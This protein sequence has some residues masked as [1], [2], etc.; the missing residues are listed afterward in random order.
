VPPREAAPEA[1]I[2]QAMEK[3]VLRCLEKEPVLRPQT[4]AE[5]AKI[6]TQALAQPDG[7]LV[8]GRAAPAS[9]IH[10]RTQGYSVGGELTE[11]VIEMTPAEQ[12]PFVTQAV[13]PSRRTSTGYSSSRRG[14]KT[15]LWLGLGALGLVAA[16]AVAL[17]LLVPGQPTT[18]PADDTSRAG[19]R[20]TS[21]RAGTVAATKEASAEA[22][23]E[24]LRT[25]KAAAKKAAD[26]A[27]QIVQ[28][29]ADKAAA[30]ATARV[31]AEAKIRRAAEE[32]ARLAAAT[33]AKANGGRRVGTP[34]SA[35]T[36][37]NVL[38]AQ[39]VAA[40]AVAKA[41][42]KAKARAAAKAAKKAAKLNAVT[43]DQF[44]LPAKDTSAP[45]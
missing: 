26:E 44:R 29:A 15:P 39:G 19:L 8:R 16:A 18:R 31:E 7:G 37:G 1:N 5:L 17:A 12:D 4:C 40:A 41:G 20:D 43:R 28:Q 24:Q 10:S 3:V 30:A 25:S 42:A 27:T 32:K 33:A 45:K 6:L 11:P 13:V 23:A 38:K 9:Q 14:S 34:K 21:R 35:P 22:L 2:S 36:T